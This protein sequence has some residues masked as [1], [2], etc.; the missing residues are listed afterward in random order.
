MRKSRIQQQYLAAPCKILLK[1]STGNV[2]SQLE[3]HIPKMLMPLEEN[4]RSEVY[5]GATTF[6]LS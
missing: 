2:K 4:L 3:D 6:L 5:G 1:F